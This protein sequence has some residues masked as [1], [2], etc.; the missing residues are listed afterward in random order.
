[1]E[2]SYDP[3]TA[4]H[5]AG[6]AVVA[7]AMDRP[8]RI[9]S[10]LPSREYL[11]LCGFGKGVVRPTKDGLEQEI[12]IS[13]AGMAAE[14]RHTGEYARDA[15]ERDLRFVRRLAVQRAGERQAE[16][17]ERRL[18]AKVENLLA[19]EGVWRAVELIVVELLQRGEIS[20]RTARH[21]YEQC[22]NSD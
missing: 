10:V 13:L 19:D 22:C 20:G 6:H 17:L 2:N 9:V 8:V 7:L 15:A 1:M 16:R 5:E 21:L 12:L 3:A 11:G 18:L 14:A 4:Y